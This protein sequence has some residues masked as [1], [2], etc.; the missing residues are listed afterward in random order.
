MSLISKVRTSLIIGS[1]LLIAAAFYYYEL[2]LS[3][4]EITPAAKETPI[5]D[6]EDQLMMLDDKSSN[7][8]KCSD[9]WYIT[10]YFTPVEENYSGEVLKVIIDGKEYSFKKNFV[11]A[12][13]IEGWG[14]AQSGDYL[15]WYAES[16]HLSDVPLDGNGHELK[17]G[18]VAVDTSLIQYGNKITIPS[19]PQPWNK[20]I[21]NAED[22]GP[23]I[24]GKHIDVY[25]GEGKDAELETMRIT[26]NENTVCILES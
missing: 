12:V 11:D 26:G 22:E 16:Y 10:G 23:A 9:D 13:R 21:F 8:S 19:L 17:I 1:V 2:S 14:R 5:K 4:N 25:T 15:G 3:S 24:I 18:T 7:L 20:Q 6:F